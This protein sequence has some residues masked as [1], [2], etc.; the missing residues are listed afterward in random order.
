MLRNE[1]YVLI[2]YWFMMQT[3]FSVIFQ[4]KI[5]VIHVPYLVLQFIQR[6]ETVDA[7]KTFTCSIS[8]AATIGCHYWSIVKNETI[9]LLRGFY[10]IL[11]YGSDNVPMTGGHRRPLEPVRI[12]PVLNKYWSRA[13]FSSRWI[14]YNCLYP[15]EFNSNLFSTFQ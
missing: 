2:L 5:F 1:K 12:N 6:D 10:N 9:L 15:K 13:F 14:H 7:N 8:M 4:F 11:L 3:W